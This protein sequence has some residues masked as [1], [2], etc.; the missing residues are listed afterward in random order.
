[1]RTAAKWYEKE[2]VDLSDVPD[3]TTD[4]EELRRLRKAMRIGA[5]TWQYA[6]DC[7]FYTAITGACP[8]ML[9][10]LEAAWAEAERWKA[11]ALRQSEEIV[12]LCREV[13]RLKKETTD[14][15]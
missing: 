12:C 2:F 13:E 4:I 8:A 10:E 7:D 14:A 5:S 9:D 11:I 6:E 3:Q 15:E 1:M